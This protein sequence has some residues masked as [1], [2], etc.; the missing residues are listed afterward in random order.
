MVDQK[1]VMR[2]LDRLG[3]N[4]SFW[5]KAELAELPKIMIQGEVI[6]HVRHGYYS[7]GFATLVATNHRLLLIDKKLFFLT[8]EDIR[9]DMIAEVDYGQQVLAATIHVR[10]FS[11]DL[12]FQSL[13]KRSLRSIT[14]FIQHKIMELRGHQTAQTVNPQVLASQ[15]IPMQ[16]FGQPS[17][18]TDELTDQQSNGVLPLD[19]ESWYKIN[20]TRKVANPYAQSPLVTRRRVGRFS[21]ANDR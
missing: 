8:V 2:Q 9:Y 11:K 21:Y 4:S 14:H 15:A 20:P 12:K 7:G 3:A 10:S 19:Q 5:G 6:E 17:Q 1:I 16:I 18:H 13:D